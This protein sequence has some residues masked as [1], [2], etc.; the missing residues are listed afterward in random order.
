M[1]AQVPILAVA[2]CLVPVFTCSFPSELQI[3]THGKPFRLKHDCAADLLSKLIWP[4][5]LV[6]SCDVLCYAM[7]TAGTARVPEIPYGHF[8]LG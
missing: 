3:T 5:K 4:A 8:A 6:G 2:S 1:L 7:L